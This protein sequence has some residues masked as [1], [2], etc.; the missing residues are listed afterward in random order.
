[1]PRTV[2]SILEDNQTF[3]DDVK[4]YLEIL[5]Q[6]DSSIAC[7]ITCQHFIQKS[8]KRVNMKV[9]YPTSEYLH[10]PRK[11]VETG[12]RPILKQH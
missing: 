2:V 1:M 5:Q 7:K 8:I 4:K 3:L 9:P 10:V 11:V 6:L 12:E